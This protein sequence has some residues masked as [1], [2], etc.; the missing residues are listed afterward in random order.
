MKDLIILGAGGTAFEVIEIV[1][2]INKS[3]HQWNILGYLDDNE[4]LI[5]KIRNGFPVLGTIPSSKNYKDAFFASSIGSAYDTKLRMKVRQKVPFPDEKFA[6][7]I[8]PNA[9]I[10]ETAKIAPGAIIYSNVCVSANTH[11]GHDV[12]LVYNTV[13]AHE[14]TIGKH[15]IL[16]VGVYLPSDVHVGECCYLGVGVVSR[17]Q[18]DIGNNCLIGMGTK[19]VKS[20]PSNSKLINKLENIVTPL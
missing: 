18:M 8:H 10:C 12:F 13:V 16:S 4:E 3:T 5:G 14:S 2:A 17:H 19:I 15:S 1:F 20:V 11:I 7:L 9:T 6:T